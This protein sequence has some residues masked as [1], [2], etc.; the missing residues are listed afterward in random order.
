PRAGAGYPAHRGGFGMTVKEFL[1]IL[2]RQWMVAALTFGVVLAIG[3]AAAYLPAERWRSSSTVIVQPRSQQ[4]L[5][6]GDAVATEF[7]LPAVVTQ[8]QGDSFQNEIKS[9]VRAQLAPAPVQDYSL[10]ASNEPG[11]GIVTVE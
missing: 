4:A 2:R 7:L 6:F 3:L 8:I 1:R 10:S 11:T 9:E 5:Q